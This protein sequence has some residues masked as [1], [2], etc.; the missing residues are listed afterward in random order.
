MLFCVSFHTVHFLNE[1]VTFYL[2]LFLARIKR[3]SELSDQIWM[4]DNL[5]NFY[6][7]NQMRIGVLWDESCVIVEWPDLDETFVQL[8][9]ARSNDRNS[10]WELTIVVRQTAET[11][12]HSHGNFEHVQSSWELSSVH[13][14]WR[15][16]E[17]RWE[18]ELSPALVS[19]CSFDPDVRH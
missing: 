13:E 5:F 17:R 8:S 6:V 2:F 12:S 4:R 7:S 15:P 18:L 19:S 11:I 1:C 10:P 16:N 3:G 14:S 9:C